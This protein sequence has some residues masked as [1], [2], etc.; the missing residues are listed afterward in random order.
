MKQFTCLINN[1]KK[2]AL[3]T[4]IKKAEGI[5]FVDNISEFCDN[6]AIMLV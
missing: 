5:K 2:I 3:E 6:N 1:L 4:S